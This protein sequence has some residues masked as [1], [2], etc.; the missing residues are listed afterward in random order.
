MILRR[1]IA[2]FKKQEW[3]AIGLDFLI[4]VIGVFVGI[5]VSNWN[6]ARENRATGA[7]YLARISEDIASDA[8][9]LEKKL[10]NLQDEAL[11]A[12]L[13]D[14]FLQGKSAGGASD[15]DMFQI[16]YYRAGWTPFTP[17]RVTYDELIST[18][19]FRLVGD[20]ALRKEI[21]DY[22]EALNEFSLFYEFQPPLRELIRSKYTPEAQAYMWDG[23]FPDAHYRSTG[24]GW[25][26][27]EP[28]NDEADIAR[29]LDA[30][31]QTEGLLDAVRYTHS[32]RLIVMGASQ[33][34]LERAQALSAKLNEALE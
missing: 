17:N 26:Q 28:L 2:H 3:T 10:T 1:V 21:G 14:D 9:F 15:W 30:L 19:Q 11:H 32:V 33:T 6:E 24:G 7:F 23:C 27:C 12:K 25:S 16:I 8:A 29:T 4:V 22:Y 20:P 34:D 5:Q 18:G 31:K 13:I